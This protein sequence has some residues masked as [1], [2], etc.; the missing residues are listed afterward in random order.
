MRLL[1]REFEARSVIPWYDK[2]GIQAAPGQRICDEV[3]NA[4]KDTTAIVICLGMKDLGR[5]A[6]FPDDFFAFELSI[7]LNL[8]DDGRP[9]I[10]L[11]HKKPDES[12]E[13]RPATVAGMDRLHCGL[14][15]KLVDRLK[16]FRRYDIYLG[17]P[18]DNFGTIM[19][20]ICEDLVRV[21]R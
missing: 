6:K 4:L 11:V 9:V 16:N 17:V 20:S 3:E 18:D 10:V 12:F 7:A 5:C 13:I 14:G 2:K 1:G 19:D 8:A 15:T 21:V